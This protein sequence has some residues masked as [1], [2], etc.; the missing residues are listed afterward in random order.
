MLYTTFSLPSG[1]V[2]SVETNRAPPLSTEAA[3]TEAS[4]VGDKIAATW[5]DGV[6]MVAELA[7]LTV[8]RLKK[9]TATAKEVSVEFGVSISGKAGLVLVEGTTAANLRVTMKW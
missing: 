5:S 3:V 6:N 9:A 7:E 1:A 4:G 8:D 2:I